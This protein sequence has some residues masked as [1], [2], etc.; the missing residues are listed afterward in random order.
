MTDLASQPTTVRREGPP[1][2]PAPPSQPTPARPPRP[3]PR[4]LIAGDT[5]RRLAR[6]LSELSIAAKRLERD[7]ARAAL[8]GRLGLAGGANLSGDSQKKLDVYAD[9]LMI[10]AL[11]VTGL[12]AGGVSEERD[13]VEAIGPADAPFLV[14]IDP[15][16]GSS[17]TDVN[18][19]V[20]T[21]F[22]IL[23]RRD[24]PLED[25]VLQPG[26]AILAAGYVMYGTSTLLVL[27]LG[28]SAQ[29]YTLDPEM[30]E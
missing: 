7:V 4:R 5:D 10:G 17:N 22:S 8:V 13:H 9:Q 24:G 30:G 26:T 23:P 27:S 14:A 21:I 18:G 2:M 1:V 29:G 25:D 20:G 3:L 15:L 28:G 11:A 19:S 6:V 16:D 12:V